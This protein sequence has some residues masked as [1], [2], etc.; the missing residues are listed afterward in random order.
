MVITLQV[1][2]LLHHCSIEFQENAHIHLVFPLRN[3][4]INISESEYILTKVHS[5]S[6][7]RNSINNLV[8]KFDNYA[9]NEY[10]YPN[11]LL[12]NT[13][14]LASKTDYVFVID[15][16]MIPSSDLSRLFTQFIQIFPALS[17]S[18]VPNHDE[19]I[20]Y[21]VPAF[22][23][24]GNI[25]LPSNK[26]GLLLLWE[27]GFVRPFYYEMC[28]KCQ[29]P[30]NFLLWKTFADPDLYVAYEVKW[31]DPWEPFFIAPRTMP[32]FDERFQ[33]YGFNRISQVCLLY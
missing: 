7:M 4:P 10:K 5:C 27:A 33:Q 11:N 31:I 18:N 26:N 14:V 8:S 28:W 23:I 9:M 20:V 2:Q 19:N 12:R 29:K 16:D 6:T 3:T 25:T 21:V 1:I 17:K 30:T 15:I 32:L 13:A 22:E 24:Q